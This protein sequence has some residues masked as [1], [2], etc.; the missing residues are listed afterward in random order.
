MRVRGE[1]H[2]RLG[3]GAEQ[4][5]VGPFDGDGRVPA[6]RGAGSRRL[7]VGDRQECLPALCQP[8]LGVLT[9]ALGAT[10]VTAG[11]VDVVFLS[12]VVALSQVTAE[13][14]GPTVDNSVH[15]AAMA[16]QEALA[17]PVEVR[18]GH[19]IATCPPSPA[20][21]GSGTLRDQP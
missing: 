8:R 18:A 11:V 21:R 4:N 12:T 9:V 19:R 15:G 6:V 13:G 16:G 2:E 20:S 14:F 5:V 17:E 1:R 7:K 3:R 10:P